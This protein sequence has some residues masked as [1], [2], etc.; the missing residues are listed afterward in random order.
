MKIAVTLNIQVYFYILFAILQSEG[1]HNKKKNADIIYN[2]LQKLGWKN[3][4]D[5]EYIKYRNENIY[6]DKIFNTRV[7]LYNCDKFIRQATI[8]LGCSYIHDLDV[9]FFILF[10]FREHCF[11]LLKSD[12][13]RAHKCTVALL[14]KMIE[15][16]PMAKIME[17][18]LN[19]IEQYHNKPMKPQNR[20]HFILSNVLTHLKKNE[21]LK[22][23]IPLNIDKASINAALFRIED[24]LSK[25]IL[26]LEEDVRYCKLITLDLCSLWKLWNTEFNTLEFQR[27]YQE[28]FIFFND[29]IN[30]LIVTTICNKY[31]ELGF[32]FDLNTSQTF[33]PTPQPNDN[34]NI[35][36]NSINFIEHNNNVNAMKNI[37]QKYIAQHS[38]I[39]LMQPNNEVDKHE[40]IKK[41][42]G[43]N[44]LE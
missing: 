42:V 37:L 7:T 41:E 22:K 12:I 8:F 44:I 11:E 13:I 9:M 16:V 38:L 20:I 19:A 39:N 4:N 40:E 24:M 23:L 31:I 5:V 35:T 26:E 29:Q 17:G 2:L 33:L 3:I 43:I 25:S 6:P 1:T 10:K 14:A 21:N 36:Q 32:K 27:K 34:Q 30:D 18:A 15:I 28:L